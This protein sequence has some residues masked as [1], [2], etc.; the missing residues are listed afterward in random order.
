MAVASATT[1]GFLGGW[2]GG[3]HADVTM[4]A[5]MAIQQGERRIRS[6]WTGSGMCREAVI[7]VMRAHSA[8]LG[9]CMYGW[10]GLG[11]GGRGHYME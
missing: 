2:V 5:A 8:P 1:V 7:S 9:H 10:A 4:T 3:K 6:G 11:V